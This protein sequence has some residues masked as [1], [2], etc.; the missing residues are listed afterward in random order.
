MAK[1]GHHQ[2]F[3]RYKV[4]RIA[5]SSS[6]SSEEI[7]SRKPLMNLICSNQQSIEEMCAHEEII[8]TGQREPAET[9]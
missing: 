3:S 4:A 2:R 8:A 7:L 1:P 5:M 9:A 6:S